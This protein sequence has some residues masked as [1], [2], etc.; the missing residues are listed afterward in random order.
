MSIDAS[1]L[2]IMVI[3]W[4]AYLVL[5]WALFAPL[6]EI[7]REREE[8]VETAQV[9]HAEAMKKADAKIDEER[10]RLS[11]ARRAAAERRDE[12]RREAEEQRQVILR[13]ANEAADATV[14]EAQGQLEEQVEEARSTLRSHAENLADRMTD[15]LLEKSA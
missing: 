9:A 11:E 5:R 4:I 15:K 1:L 8:A 12:L 3:F 14:A 13:E 10:A 2:V 6:A 7:L